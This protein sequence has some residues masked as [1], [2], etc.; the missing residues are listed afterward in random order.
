MN[1]ITIEQVV[2]RWT[3][4]DRP[5]LWKGIL[6]GGAG[7][8]DDPICRCAQGDI[9]HFAGFTDEELRNLNQAKADLEVSQRLG[10][11][12]CHAAL[13]RRVNDTQDGCPEDVLRAP[14]K[15]LGPNAQTVLAFWRHL[16]R[17][18]EAD[19]IKF[20]DA[21]KDARAAW[22]ARAAKDAWDARAAWAA[23][24]YASVEIQFPEKMVKEGETF[25]FLP[26]FGFADPTAVLAADFAFKSGDQ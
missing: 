15:I 10:I 2:A 3:S 4:E 12:V 6:I 21:A 13:L 8:P 18:T 1:P 7:T 16:D 25:F 11:S 5:K 26:L 17:M 24:G 14:E 23:V 22:D 9:L 19:W 20:F